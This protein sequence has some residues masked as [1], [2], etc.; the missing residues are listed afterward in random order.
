MTSFSSL[1]AGESVFIRDLRLCVDSD[2]E[3]LRFFFEDFL[4]SSS[5]TGDDNCSETTT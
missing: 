4:V 3:R 1:T 2:F 5:L